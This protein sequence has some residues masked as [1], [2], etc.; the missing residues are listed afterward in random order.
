MCYYDG[1]MQLT[2]GIVCRVVNNNIYIRAIFLIT[3]K[4]YNEFRKK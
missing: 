2:A 3:G 1:Y 4:R